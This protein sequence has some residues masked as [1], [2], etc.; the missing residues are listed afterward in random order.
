MILNPQRQDGSMHVVIVVVLV[1]IIGV[2]GFAFY[3]NFVNK[4]SANQN[5]TTVD[6]SGEN[7]SN[8]PSMTPVYTLNNAITGIN[9][10]LAEKGCGS[11]VKNVISSDAFSEVEDNAQYSYQG[12]ISKVNKGLSYA[13]AQYGCGSQGSTALLKK[14]ND[15]WVLV[16]EDARTYPMCS[17]IRGQGFPGSIVDKCYEN[18]RSTEPVTI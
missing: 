11:G 7:E 2:L 6:E 3:Q 17:V 13:F 8:S 1:V 5:P 14:V 16:S 4:D 15:E 12:G 9:K 18:D 10:T